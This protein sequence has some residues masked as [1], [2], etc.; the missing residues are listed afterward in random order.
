MPKTR[1]PT[2]GRKKSRYPVKKRYPTKK[3]NMR[4][5]SKMAKPFPMGQSFSTK[6]TSSI[7]Q[8]V[9]ATPVADYVIRA[10]SLF[11]NGLD[12][13]QPLGF[14]EFCPA[15]YQ[16]YRVTGC[17]IVAKYVNT[18]TTPT[19]ASVIPAN[20]STSITSMNSARAI[21]GSQSSISLS[22]AV[23]STPTYHKLYRNSSYVL[24]NNK[25]T[26][27]DEDFAGTSVSDPSH[28]WYLHLNAQ[29]LDETTAIT[30]YWVVTLV[31]Y[32]TFFDRKHLL[33]S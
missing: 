12:S 8:A 31:Y 9:S 30:G 5:S 22:N 10:N 17:K 6:L 26:M 18:S 29:A 25:Q 16:K 14:D 19:V 32:A 11:S 13:T 33:L 20:T 23:Q 21:A 7:T 15:I 27:K 28:M 3:S 4:Y 24:G 1:E 2:Y